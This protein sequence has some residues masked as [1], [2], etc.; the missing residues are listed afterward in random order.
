MRRRNSN[1]IAEQASKQI[2]R[3]SNLFWKSRRSA[4]LARFRSAAARP[5]GILTWRSAIGFELTR[6][7]TPLEARESGKRVRMSSATKTS[8]LR[9]SERR[10]AIIS[11][12]RRAAL[13]QGSGILNHPVPGMAEQMQIGAYWTPDPCTHRLKMDHRSSS[14]AGRCD[15]RFRGRRELF[16]IEY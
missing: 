9:S 16:T 13:S 2:P 10:F 3:N 12:E 14:S 7:R 11:K 5:C 6:G 4:G 15:R 1:L 8:S